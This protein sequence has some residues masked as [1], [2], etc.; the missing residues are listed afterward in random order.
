MPT[1]ELAVKAAEVATPFTP[2]VAVLT[3]PAKVPPAPLPGA[4]KVTVTPWIGLLPESRTVATR[5][6]AKAVEMVALCGEPLVR[7]SEAGAPAVLVKA[8]L[9][10]VTPVTEATTL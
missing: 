1:V 10:E 8:K 9:T 7:V 5:G 4:A 3:P 6:A 2:V